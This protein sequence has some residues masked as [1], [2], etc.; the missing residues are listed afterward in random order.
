VTVPLPK[1]DERTARDICEEVRS[2]LP[3]WSE[4]K[5]GLDAALINIFAR[6]AELIIHRLN[7]APE[8]NLLAFLDLL[9]VSQLP[10]QAARV[11]LTFSMAPGSATSARV[12]AGTQVAAPPGNGD[13][14]PVIFET[15]R[16]L[17][18]TTARLD[19][20]LIKFG[21]R[22]Q[23]RDLSSILPS[24][25]DGAVADSLTLTETKSVPHVLYIAIPVGASWPQ[26][27]Q[28]RIRFV[29]DGG[30][31][32]M[33]DERLLQWEICT[34]DDPPRAVAGA[35]TPKP[36]PVPAPA[37][38]KPIVLIPHDDST[39]NLTQSG[40]IVFQ[41][42]PSI[43]L[44]AMEGVSGHWLGCRLLT[45]ISRSL[46]PVSAM[47]SASQLPAVK[48]VTAEMQLARKSL[49]LEQAFYNGQKLDLTKDFFPFGERPK[50]SDTLYLASREAFSNPDAKI[51]LHVQLTN[52]DSAGPD[53][54]IPNT[55]T[56]NTQLSW[57]FWNGQE[58]T[59]LG[60]SGRYLRLGDGAADAVDTE[61]T[62]ETKS[63]STDGDVSF[64]FS[65]P[66]AELNLN[67]QKNYW[68]RTRIVAGNYGAEPQFQT[69]PASGRLVAKPATLAPP[70]IRSIKLDY[71][72][73][74]EAPPTAVLTY[75]DFVYAKAN[76]Q[77]P[78]KPFLPIAPED[79]SPAIHFGFAVDLPVAGNRSGDSG[80]PAS[81]EGRQRK[82][83]YQQVS[84]Y[85]VVG[86]ETSQKSGEPSVDLGVSTWEY[87]DG[88]AWRKCSVTDETQCFRRSGLIQ[89]LVPQNFVTKKEFGRERYWLRMRSSA[90]DFDPNIRNV[91]L[92]TITAIQGSSIA[93]DI[94][95]SSNGKAN[96][97]FQTTQA[98]VLSGQKLE[99][100]E[101]TM[102]PAHERKAIEKDE[103]GGAIQ[104]AAEIKGQPK[105]YWVTWHE[106]ANFYGSEPRD[107]HYVLDHVK[108][109]V[110]FGDGTCG[111]I[112][113]VLPGNIRMTRYRSGGGLAG[114]QPAQAIAKL[115]SAVPYIQKVANWI[116]ASGGT[117][118]EAD[119]MLLDRGPR[120][121]RHGGRAVTF[122]DFE[123]LA[124]LA[125][126]EV[127]RAK[128]V[129]LYDLSLPP[130][131][132]RLRPG[133]VS[134]IVVPRS[135]DPRP[136]P[137]ADL[138]A[139]VRTFLDAWRLP[140]VDLV[141][142]GAEYVRV[143]VDVE[144]VV[145][146]SGEASEVERTVREKLDEYLHPV[147]GGP[148]G[149]GWDFGRLPQKFDLCVQ[150]EQIR[151]VNH[152]RDLRVNAVADHAGAEK[153]R[154]FL[155]CSGQYKIALTLEETSAVEF[156]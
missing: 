34:Q 4:H 36:A 84:A 92:N 116:P 139:R 93:N 141:V 73:N 149:W 42:L 30:A 6:F 142:T 66:P 128:C 28:L 27:D 64:R 152:I 101:P 145:D 80:V 8:K 25:S 89:S 103:E 90:P 16:D 20:L 95:G 133:L 13:P 98:K 81:V 22:D 65:R 5:R 102:P 61:F 44:V 33:V 113:P 126:R 132:R 104:P 155:I 31:N 118:P 75:N 146:D 124:M 131:A 10:M 99:V 59:R 37:T 49:A 39:K 127:A 143:D 47:V 43:P 70:S 111:M 115:A 63:L 74:K 55:T 17:V 136:L 15:D 122:E 23:Y 87:W 138:L 58:W 134:L 9:G 110:M 54:G 18:V 67:G 45:P 107:R 38:D 76:T 40:D 129:P 14:K 83:P 35:P 123:D 105:Q 108:G 109:E 117:D 32:P 11:P 106:V 86:N 24:P 2:L 125:S 148:D 21:G 151:G 154:H 97:K 130:A 3:S 29:L 12:P 85:V 140:T 69:D 100:R 96:Q 153:T 137:D 82:F 7:Q 144:I 72:V 112:P 26:I 60:Q 119:A 147:S 62:D 68:I 77:H 120:G 46:Q 57:E 56:H 135:M 150:L 41:N 51:T 94:L 156:A 121:V 78:F 19:S 79:S 1:L 52:P 88:I 71:E 114:N 91:Y 50:F 48:E 53:V